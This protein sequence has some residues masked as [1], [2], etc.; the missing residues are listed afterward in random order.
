M[1]PPLASI[2]RTFSSSQAETLSPLHRNSRV[3]FAP[4]PWQ[5][6]FCFLSLGASSHHF[7]KHKTPSLCSILAGWGLAFDCRYSLWGQTQGGLSSWANAACTRLH[8]ILPVCPC[9]PDRGRGQG[10]AAVSGWS[11]G[12][13]LPLYFGYSRVDR[14]SW[15][16]KAV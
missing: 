16:L 6:A 9:G 5:P 2:S 13:R 8:I 11:L 12:W 14:G 1:Q 7:C 10:E 3:P 15:I 4:G